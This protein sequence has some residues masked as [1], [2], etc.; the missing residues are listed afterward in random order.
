MNEIIL[1]IGFIL[2]VC[3]FVFLRYR[4]K[5]YMQKSVKDALGKDLKQEIEEERELY[6]KHKEKF[7][8]AFDH[9]KEEK[10]KAHLFTERLK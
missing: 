8:Q 9:A 1:T 4:D 10:D 7:N 6:F 3:F 2:G 5:K